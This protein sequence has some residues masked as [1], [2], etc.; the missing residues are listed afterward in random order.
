[1]HAMA[2][3]LP[4]SEPVE[5][6]SNA[7][8]DL[9]LRRAQAGEHAAWRVLVERFQKP[10]HALIWRLLAGRAQHRAPDLT[11]ETFVRVLRALPKFDARGPAKL[12]TWILTIAT[13]L[14]LNELRRPEPEPLAIEPV[15][16]TRDDS[17]LERKRLG[18]AIATAIAELPDPQRAVLV[19]R[20]YHELDYGEIAEA[21]ELDIG[22]VK[23]R[24]SRARAALRAHLTE[25]GVGR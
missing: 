18:E 5:P 25:L 20:E 4:P 8:D 12:S 23:S 7:L 22:T 13:R 2:A 19:L 16:A 9:T 24:L 1:M 14:A 6:V 11:Q 10:V 15:A 21:L 17:D 3:L